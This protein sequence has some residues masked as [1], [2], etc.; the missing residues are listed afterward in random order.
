MGTGQA[1]GDPE[2]IGLRLDLGLGLNLYQGSK[3][4]SNRKRSGQYTRTVKHSGSEGDASLR[5]TSPAHINPVATLLLPHSVLQ[6]GGLHPFVRLVVRVAE[7][8]AAFLAPRTRDRRRTRPSDRRPLTSLVATLPLPYI[9]LVSRRCR[10]TSTWYARITKRHSGR[11]H[12][13]TSCRHT[14]TPPAQR[15]DGGPMPSP[16]STTPSY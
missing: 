2:E 12:L 8:N 10:I 16:S 6:L 11:Q 14:A 13:A 1:R 7:C 3:R 9:T 15:R 5:S 4:D